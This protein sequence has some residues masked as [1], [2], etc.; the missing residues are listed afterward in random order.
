MWKA[1]ARVEDEAKPGALVHWQAG[2]G[3]A[4]YTAEQSGTEDRCLR[5]RILLE[6]ILLEDR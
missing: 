1:G 4:L 6:G 2:T 5:A 3:L